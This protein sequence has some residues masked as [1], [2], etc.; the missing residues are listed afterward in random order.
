M[1]GVPFRLPLWAFNLAELIKFFDASQAS[2]VPVL[3]RVVTAAR[4]KTV[5][6]AATVVLRNVVAEI[7]AV[8]TY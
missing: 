3:E 4:E 6:A 2:Q 7:D 8:A 5:G 1:D